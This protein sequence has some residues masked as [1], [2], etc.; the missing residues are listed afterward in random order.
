MS[1]IEFKNV[2]YTYPQKTQY[3]LENITFSVKEGEFLAVMGENSAGKTTLC[4]LIN[5]L[6]PH[7]YGGRLS[8]T[9]TVDGLNT[10]ECTVPQLALK[11]GIVFD[12]PDAQLFT[13][14][15]RHEAAFGPENLLLPTDEIEE[16]IT[17]ALCATG[18]KGFEDRAP[19]TLSGGEKQR[20]SIAAALAMKGKILVL[21]DPLCRLDPD[22][23]QEVMTVLNDIRSK[24]QITVVFVSGGS[25]IMSKHADRVCVLNNGRIAAL[26]RAE[27]IFSDNDLLEKN[28]IMPLI[29]ENLNKK[30]Q[31][32]S[33]LLITGSS[34]SFSKTL[35]STA[36]DSKVYSRLQNS[37]S[38]AAAKQFFVLTPCKTA[39]FKGSSYKTEVLQE[40]LY[41]SDKEAVRI[42][43]FSYLYPDCVSIKNVNITIYDN[44]FIALTG[45]NGCGK[46]TLLK[47]ITGLLRPSGGD[48]Y[49]RGKNTKELSIAAISK[50][51][52]FVMQNPGTQLFTDS[53]FNEAA[54]ALKNMRRELCLSKS[55]IT[56]RVKDAL[57]TVGLYDE[58]AFPHALSGPDK[59]KIVIACVLAM[60]C[61]IIILDEVDARND[62]RG[63][64]KI[65]DIVRELHSKGFTIIF[66]THNMYLVDRYAQ[67]L[68]KM[69]RDGIYE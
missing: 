61:R 50:E 69:E 16:R 51:A 55:E 46:T 53:V 33:D 4:K 19:S 11:A 64:L 23:A 5:G 26:D 7:H 49:I 9:V 59:T 10:A 21:D 30:P 1:I 62:Y 38:F 43:N 63:S 54:F 28:G 8:G 25:E 36:A 31:S 20:L 35:R 39:V 57:E 41:I 29:A 56:R 34:N 40:L 24:Y 27:N 32:S 37:V 2:F 52:G 15:V 67:R 60:G 68:I 17:F 22:G 47:N 18:L 6:I 13:S 58:N 14:T 42:D 45:K 48:I 44:D 12:D 66:V 65:M 3:A